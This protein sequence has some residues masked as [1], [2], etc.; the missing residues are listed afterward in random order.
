MPIP[1]KLVDVSHPSRDDELS[2]AL[3]AA[4]PTWD[5]RRSV[6]GV[7]LVDLSVADAALHCRFPFRMGGG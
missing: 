4:Q 6:V 5:I 1:D 7:F 2:V 3:V